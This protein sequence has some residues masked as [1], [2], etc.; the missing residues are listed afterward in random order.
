VPS[1]NCSNT[2]DWVCVWPNLLVTG[3]QNKASIPVRVTGIRDRVGNR[4]PGSYSAEFIYDNIAPRFQNASIMPLGTDLSVLMEGDIASVTTYVWEADSGLF[5][6]MANYTFSNETAAGACEAYDSWCNGDSTCLAKSKGLW[7]CKWEYSGSLPV[8]K[9]AVV[10]FKAVDF[11]GNS[12]LSVQ[13]N[14]RA[15]AYVAKRTDKVVDFWKDSA[16]VSD[17]SKLNRNFLWMSNQGSV[18]KAT[19][20]LEPKAKAYV[21]A[22]NI[23]GCS[24]TLV[25]PDKLDVVEDY[26]VEDQFYFPGKEKSSKLVLLRIPHMQKASLAN[27]T[28]VR[29]VCDGEIVQGRASRGEIYSPNEEFNATVIVELTKDVFSQPDLAQLDKINYMKKGLKNINSLI[30]MIKWWVNLAQPLCTLVN[31]VRQTLSNVCLIWNGIRMFT[32]QDVVAAPNQCFV[33]FEYLEELYMGKKADRMTDWGSTKAFWSIGFWCD[34]VLCEDCTNFWKKNL[35]NVF[36]LDVGGFEKKISTDWWS[37]W[38]WGKETDATKLL[39]PDRLSDQRGLY[40]AEERARGLGS[41]QPAFSVDPKNSLIFGTI[42]LPPCLSGILNKLYVYKNIIV[43][44]NVCMNTA[45]VRGTDIAECDNYYSSQVCQQIVGEF[46]QIADRFIKDYLVKLAMWAV[47]EKWLHLSECNE[48]AAKSSSIWSS[49]C[50]T[51][52]L[53]RITGALLTIVDTAQNLESIFN[54]QYFSD[55]KKVEDEATKRVKDAK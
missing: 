13:D 54:H 2:G 38:K 53:Y 50:I 16:A 6:V 28:S 22:M 10:T 51:K 36:G 14:I 43:T 7:R 1:A 21:H 24:G 37:S 41:Y 3:R 30:N 49:E 45:A 4:Y 8:G 19:L 9:D 15:S 33:N 34:T 40:T 31:L 44:Y 42:C 23:V 5:E 25:V 26:A 17:V 29:I 55:D 20:K 35:G 39:N 12:R 32:F 47:E 52:N 46:W 27:A 18:V 48:V 11:A